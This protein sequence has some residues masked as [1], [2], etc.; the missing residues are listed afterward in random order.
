MRVFLRCNEESYSRSL[1]HDS[2]TS[3]TVG[4]GYVAEALRKQHKGIVVAQPR[5]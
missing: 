5:A 1:P 2:I 4:R 3:S